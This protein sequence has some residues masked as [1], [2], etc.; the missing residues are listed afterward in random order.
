MITLFG[1]LC[2]VLCLAILGA[3]RVTR[4]ATRDRDDLAVEKAMVASERLGLVRDRENLNT[5]AVNVRAEPPLDLVPESA[6]A[7]ALCDRG[8]GGGTAGL[9]YLRCIQMPPTPDGEPFAHI[10]IRWTG[11]VID[12]RGPLLI[13]LDTLNKGHKGRKPK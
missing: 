3:L 9:I 11:N 1:V 7:L 10:E 13:A 4:A 2:F 6:L 5:L 8:A 12:P